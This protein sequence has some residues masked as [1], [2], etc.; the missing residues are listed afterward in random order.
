MFCTDFFVKKGLVKRKVLEIQFRIRI[1]II[2][3][4]YLQEY[5]QHTH[6]SVFLLGK[7]LIY[8]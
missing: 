3:L 7:L 5:R 2:L 6:S 4:I 1:Q 8:R